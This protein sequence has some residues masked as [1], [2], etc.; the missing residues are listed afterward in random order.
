MRS[1]LVFIALNTASVYLVQQILDEFVVTGGTLGFVFIGV[2]IGLLNVF[3]KPLLKIL[4]LPFIFLTA[5]LF[6]LVLNALILWVAQSV[7]NG[8]GIS[9]I[10]LTIGGMGT[11]VAAVLLFGIL[12]Y[13]FQK[14]LR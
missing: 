6:V 2:I 9:G 10:S 12:N 8:V 7:V 5:G 1:I 3:I 4:S 14:L 11:Y 13:I